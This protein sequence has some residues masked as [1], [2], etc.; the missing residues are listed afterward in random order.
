MYSADFGCFIITQNSSKY[1][2]VF[3]CVARFKATLAVI[4]SYS[5]HYTKLYEAGLIKKEIDLGIHIMPG[6][7]EQ[8]FGFQ[9]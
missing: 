8:F 6:L 2:M 9:V 3:L 7:M 5:I 1:R 4:T